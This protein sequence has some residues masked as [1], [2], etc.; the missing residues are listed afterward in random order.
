MKKIIVL[1]GPSGSGKTILGQLALRPIGG[2]E[3][4][5]TTTRTPRKG[6]IDGVSYNFIS[7][8]QFQYLVTSGAMLEWTEYAGQFYGL[9][10]KTVQNM[11]EKHELVYAVLDICGARA[12]KKAFPDTV[13]VFVKVSPD[14]IYRRMMERGD[15]CES[16]KIRIE[17][18]RLT[19]EFDNG[20]YCDVIIDNERP[21]DEV[22][23]E[24]QEVV[25]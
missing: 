8:E 12:M 5:S 9:S 11:M 24:L 17:N 1:V 16:V 7:K 2:V 23:K 15:D 25:K 22:I 6:E 14:T 21:L 3:L 10:A 4:V 18:A 19:N 20:Q 13:T